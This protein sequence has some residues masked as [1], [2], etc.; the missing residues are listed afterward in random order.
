ML[1]E[2][3]HNLISFGCFSGFLKFFYQH[4]WPQSVKFA[5]AYVRYI[6]GCKKIKCANVFESFNAQKLLD[7]KIK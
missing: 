6:V 7:L 2:T 4:F 5:K 3:F 1:F